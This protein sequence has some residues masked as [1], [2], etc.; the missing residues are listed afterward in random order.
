[1]RLGEARY[2]VAHV[3]QYDEPT[4]E[5]AAAI[6]AEHDDTLVDEVEADEAA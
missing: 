2:V 4:V 5:A 3:E 1:M 6:I